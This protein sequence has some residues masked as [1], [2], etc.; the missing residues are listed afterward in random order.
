M[1]SCPKCDAIYYDETLEFCTEDGSN[2]IKPLNKTEEIPTVLRTKIQDPTNAKTL[3]LPINATAEIQNN[4]IDD[5]ILNIKEKVTYQ[6]IKTIEVIPI[7]L[8][9]AHNYWQW[10]YFDKANFDKTIDLLISANFLIW[11]LLLLLGGIFSF[12]ALQYGKNKG[13]AITS[14]VILAINILLSIVPLK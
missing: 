12:L 11:I 1:K 7:I 10:I 3:N 9:L 13:F 2:L 5:K 14:L 8:A 4:K 6:G